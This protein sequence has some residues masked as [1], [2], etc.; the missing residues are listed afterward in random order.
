MHH[1]GWARFEQNALAVQF[2][3]ARVII[4]TLFMTFFEACSFSGRGRNQLIN[5]VRLIGDDD[6]GKRLLTNIRRK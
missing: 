1:T 3:F 4:R 2:F 5:V 6:F